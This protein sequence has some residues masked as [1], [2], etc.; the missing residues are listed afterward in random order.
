M[1]IGLYVAFFLS[2]RR[3]WVYI[4]KEENADRCRILI[5]GTSNKNKIAFEK[6]FTALVECLTHDST[7]QNA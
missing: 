6:E 3:V 5:C 4:S 2:H 1:L 7:F